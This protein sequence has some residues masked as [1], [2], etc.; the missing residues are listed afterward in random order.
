MI[1][2]NPSSYEAVYSTLVFVK[3]EIKKKKICCTSLTFDQPLYWKASEIKEDK[4]PELDSIH[5]TRRFSPV[6]VFPWSWM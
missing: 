5:L 1:P 6:N 2:I 3:D 4:A